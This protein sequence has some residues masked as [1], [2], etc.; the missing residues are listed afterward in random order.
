M[1]GK[2]L[3]NRLE[4][5]VPGLGNPTPHNSKVKITNRGG[6]HDRQSHSPP[7]PPKPLPSDGV[8]R[9]SGRSKIPCIGPNPPPPPRPPH[10]VRAT[11]NGLN[12]PPPSAGAG[13]PIR[14]NHD[15]PHMPSVAGKPPKGTPINHKPPT[16]PG[17]DNHPEH[18][19]GPLPGSHPVLP[20]R[21]TD[22]V[23]TKR[24]GH[25][26]QLP[27]PLHQRKLPPSTNIDRRNRPSGGVYGP[28]TPN[29]NPVNIPNLQL[30]N[31]RTKRSKRIAPSRP[32][33]MP[34]QPP[35]R[36]HNP[37]SDL[38]APN[39]Q[40]QHG[41]PATPTLPLELRQQAIHNPNRPGPSPHWRN[42]PNPS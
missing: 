10:K 2:R 17:G 30:P 9:V 41:H 32:S 22:S 6:G 19:T 20:K 4:E 15:M 7:S 1:N 38:G 35:P 12:T 37:T 13:L 16:N 14:L 21:N 11:G 18:G 3:P 8:P 42:H 24:D 40:R 26:N 36:V 39:V 28:S 27:N 34:Q 25:P 29:P 5:E 31:H 23:P 33:G